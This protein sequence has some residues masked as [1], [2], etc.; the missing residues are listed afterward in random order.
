MVFLEE[1]TGDA[2][3]LNLDMF[4]ETLPYRLGTDGAITCDRTRLSVIEKGYLTVRFQRQGQRAILTPSDVRP[5]L[6]FPSI[7]GIES[8]DHTTDT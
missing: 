2:P 4:Y 5:N 6:H 3:S 7:F 8:E 1:D